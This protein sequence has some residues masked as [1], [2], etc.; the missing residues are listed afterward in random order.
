MP[1]ISDISA[2]PKMTSNNT[3]SGIVTA[4]SFASATYTPYKAFDGLNSAISDVWQTGSGIVTGWLAYEFPQPITIGKYSMEGNP[5]EIS[6]GRQPRDW[7]FEGSNNGITWTVLDTQVGISDWQSNI[8]KEFIITN[9]GNYKHY[10]I[11]VTLI[12]GGSN[13]V[14]IG[15]MEMFE[16]TFEDTKLAIKNQLTSKAYSLDNKTLIHL[17]SSSDKNMIL[18]GIESGKEIKLDEDFDKMKYIKDTSE[19]LGEGKIFTHALDMNN[20]KVNKIIL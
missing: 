7:T 3:P 14:A 8:K 5:T 20:T 15:E 1:K 17:P 6:L 9:V 10:R 2:I 13:N 18:H 11:N 12:N 4:S 19:V 16:L